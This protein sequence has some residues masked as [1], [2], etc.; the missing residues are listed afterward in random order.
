P[1]VICQTQTRNARGANATEMLVG[2]GDAHGLPRDGPSTVCASPASGEAGV[3]GH[4]APPTPSRSRPGV[5]EPRPRSVFGSYL[6]VMSGFEVVPAS[7]ILHRNTVATTSTVRRRI[8]VHT[9][10]RR[11]SA[12]TRPVLPLPRSTDPPPQ[13]SSSPP[14]F[15]SFS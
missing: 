2:Q 5:S 15:A 1:D 8:L 7:L 13:P 6:W 9:L 11:P 4:L 3:A 12:A 10:R 14:P